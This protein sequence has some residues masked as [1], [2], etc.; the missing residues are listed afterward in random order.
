MREVPTY[1]GMVPGYEA[2]R[3]PEGPKKKASW[4]R[5]LPPKSEVEE[6]V[7]AGTKTPEEVLKKQIEKDS[8]SV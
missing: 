7:E 4:K 1:G 2:P 6:I 5:D 3:P 8:G